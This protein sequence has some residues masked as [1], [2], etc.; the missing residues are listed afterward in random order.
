MRARF[1]G[2][3]N[4]DGPEVI[5]YFDETFHK[6]KWLPINPKWEFLPKL[7][8]NGHFEV[9]AFNGADPAAF[10]HD[11]DGDPGGDAGATEEKAEGQP[12]AK[13]KPGRPRKA[14]N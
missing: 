14:A 9:E 10:D 3:E 5:N 11:K 12:E 8:G 2:D 7:K 13:R 1:I 6:G 4:G